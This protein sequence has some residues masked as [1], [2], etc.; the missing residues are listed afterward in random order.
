MNRDYTYFCDDESHEEYTKTFSW[1]LATFEKKRDSIKCPHCKKDMLIDI[2][3]R[4]I[5]D[6]N[7]IG[8]RTCLKPRLN[9]A[10]SANGRDGRSFF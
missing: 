9:Y 3:P 7:S 6:N 8:N 10:K 5:K 2:S 4:Q 1:G